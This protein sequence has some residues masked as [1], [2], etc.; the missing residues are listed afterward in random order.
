MLH[1]T[2]KL[3]RSGPTKA[4]KD[5]AKYVKQAKK[6]PH[7]VVGYPASEIGAKKYPNS[8]VYVMAVAFWNEYG[9]KHIPER[10]FL[11]KTLKSK[12][13]DYRRMIYDAAKKGIRGGSLKK[14]L[15]RIGG[16]AVGDIQRTIIELR[17]PPNAPSTIKRKK[18]SNPLV[19]TLELRNST[20]YALKEGQGGKI[21]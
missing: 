20:T 8:D 9:T 2:S 1:S 14:Y 19:N 4:G 15:N 7:I 17:Q 11:R 10:P 16:Q 12:R 6:A 13:Q 18:S 3:K 5:L 21:K